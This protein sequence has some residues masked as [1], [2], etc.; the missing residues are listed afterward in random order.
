M[1]HPADTS[2]ILLLGTHRSGTTWLGSVLSGHPDLAYVEEPRHIW[3]WGNADL[4]DDRLDASHA[5]PEVVDHIRRAFEREVVRQGRRRLI[6]KTPSNCLR[7]PF[8]RAVYPEATLL[9]VVRDGRSV[10]R[11]TAEIMA[12]GVP[13]RNALKRAVRTPLRDWPAQTGKVL[14][15]LRQKLT[16][17]SLR[18]WGARPPGWRDWLEHDHP[19]VVLAKQ[20][21][22]MITSV[23]D[24]LEALPLREDGSCPYHLFR[25]EDA[26]AEPDPTLHRIAQHARLDRA[27][28][29]AARARATARPDSVEAWRDELDASTLERIRPHM[30]PALNRLGYDWEGSA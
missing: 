12:G 17:G 1:T 30:E 23:L 14:D 11:S 25:Y 4:P 27:E 21:S 9:L 20:W 5:R 7:V 13:A 8:V 10:I 3:S 26:A 2:P 19:D 16:G 29:L 6:E 28:L 18:F 22:A 15:M 24:D